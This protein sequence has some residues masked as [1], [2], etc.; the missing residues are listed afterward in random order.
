MAIFF[1]RPRPFV[2]TAF[3]FF[4]VV[5]RA[6]TEEARRTGLAAVVLRAGA[7]AVRLIGR[8]GIS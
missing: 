7:E 3:D 6:G 8:F 5:F 1:G 2:S 4:A